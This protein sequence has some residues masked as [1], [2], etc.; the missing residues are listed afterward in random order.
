MF[1]RYL[2]ELQKLSMDM[3]K[4]IYV[5]MNKVQSVLKH[6]YFKFTSCFKFDYYYTYTKKIYGVHEETVT[7][8]QTS[9]AFNICEFDIFKS[10]TNIFANI[11]IKAGYIHV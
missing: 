2:L 8:K 10:E 4:Y 7:S 6:K 9:L 11:S 5:Y 1:S 3:L